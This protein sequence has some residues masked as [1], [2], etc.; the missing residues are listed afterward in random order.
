MAGLLCLGL[1][2]CSVKNPHR[3]YDSGGDQGAL[4][5]QQAGADTNSDGTTPSDA[6]ASP[7]S[8]GHGVIKIYV[9]GDLLPITYKDGLS[10]QTPVNYQIALS[11]YYI[12]KSANDP[13]PTLCFDHKKSFVSDIYKDNLVGL[14]RTKDIK[15]GVYTH[16]R[17]KVDWARYT[18]DGTYHLGIQKY[19]GK[20]TFFRAYSDVVYNNKSYKAGTGTITFS[21][22][23]TVSIPMIYGPLPPMPGVSFKTINGEFLMTFLYTKP[24]PISQTSTKVHWARF[25]WKIHKSFRW[26]D[27]K[28]PGFQ[29]GVWDVAA[30]FTNTELVKMHGVHSHYVTS[31]V[32]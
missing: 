20:F 9:R 26:L 21:G 19:P 31:S 7:D 6:T 23:T 5:D 25:H 13:A 28:L 3:D 1:L 14:C 8:P 16:G 32:D 24:L 27:S 4:T 11:R 29:S 18:V 17:T 12:L 10:G 22:L 2:G 30:I 15:T